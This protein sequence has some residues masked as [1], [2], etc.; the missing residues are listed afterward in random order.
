MAKKF[1]FRYVNEIAGGFVI[2][3]AALLIVGVV[4]AG[5]AQR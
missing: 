3:V 5:H 2:L 4:V 1:K